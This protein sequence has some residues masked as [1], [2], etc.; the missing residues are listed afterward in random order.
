MFVQGSL[1]DAGT[2]VV[3]SARSPS[4]VRIDLDERCWLDHH[5]ELAR[6]AQT[7]SSTSCSTAS[8]GSVPRCRCTTASSSSRAG[9]AGFAIGER[10]DFPYVDAMAA[11]LGDQLWRHVPIRVVQPLLRRPRQRGLA[12]RPRLARSVRRPRGDR[13]GRPPPPLLIK[14][15]GGGPSRTFEL[16]RGDLFVMGGDCQRQWR[17]CVPKVSPASLVGPRISITMRPG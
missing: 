1:L 8:P 13:V 17:H 15:A 4:C 6:K 5:T 7:S 3:R 11:A 9:T 10:F 2:P 14:P 12:R 16:G